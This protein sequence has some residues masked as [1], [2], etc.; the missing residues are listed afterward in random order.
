MQII[1]PLPDNYQAARIRYD[2][3]HTSVDA[4]RFMVGANSLLGYDKQAPQNA[5]VHNFCLET[6]IED[7]RPNNGRFVQIQ[8]AASS[9]RFVALRL[10]PGMDL[11]DALE[12][13]IKRHN[14]RAAAVVTCVGSLNHANLRLANAEQAQ[15][16]PGKLEIVSLTGTLSPDGVHLHISVSDNT[17]RTFGGHLLH[18]SPIYTTA[19]IVLVELPEIAFTR[20]T[21]VETSYRELVIRKRD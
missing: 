6:D 10:R 5:C 21:D 8:D 19:E 11:R 4:L 2:T 15:V 18:G 17:G 20:E 3:K 16:F 12:A 9:G 7:L 14:L 1:E 13:A